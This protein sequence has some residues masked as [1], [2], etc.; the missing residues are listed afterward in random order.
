M[1]AGTAQAGIRLLSGDL[2]LDVPLRRWVGLCSQPRAGHTWLEPAA[3][4]FPRFM[5]CS[6]FGALGFLLASVPLFSGFPSQR[7]AA[8]L[9]I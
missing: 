5:E 8:T 6:H 1:A 2:V 3:L 4:P 7:E 9:G